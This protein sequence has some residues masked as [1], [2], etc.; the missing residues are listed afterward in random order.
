MYNFL[1]APSRQISSRNLSPSCQPLTPEE[2]QTLTQPRNQALLDSYFEFNAAMNDLLSLMAQARESSLNISA[3][4]DWYSIGRG[5]FNLLSGFCSAALGSAFARTESAHSTMRGL[6]GQSQETGLVQ[7][8]VSVPTNVH[9]NQV[10]INIAN[11]CTGGE[12]EENRNLYTSPAFQ[13]IQAECSSTSLEPAA[14]RPKTTKPTV[15]MPS[16]S[17]T[18]LVRPESQTQVLPAQQPT[19]PP[20]TAMLFEVI[21]Q[22]QEQLRQQQEQLQLLQQLIQVHPLFTVGAQ[23]VPPTAK[24][25][26]RPKKPSQATSLAAA[27]VLTNVPIGTKRKR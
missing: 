8:Q 1:N 23:A 22:Q 18:P 4:L 3:A 26:G 20:E 17:T 14:K 15:A 11:R 16:E 10:T 19:T 12:L 6:E 25:R 24:K 2:K 5:G 13:A 21:R 27:P 7:T 9:D